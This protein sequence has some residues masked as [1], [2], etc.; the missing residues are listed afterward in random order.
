MILNNTKQIPESIL[1]KQVCSEIRMN[2]LAFKS[3]LKLNADIQRMEARQ[4]IKSLEAAHQR[5][6]YHS[7]A[8]NSDGSIIEISNSSDTTSPQH[9][10][11][12]MRQPIL[13]KLIHFENHAEIAYRLDAIVNEQPIAVFLSQE[14]IGCGTYLCHKLSA[15]GITFFT[16]SPS[17][18]KQYATNLLCLLM[19]Q[20]KQMELIYDEPGWHLTPENNFIFITKEDT[21]WNSLIQITR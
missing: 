21:T 9:L 14:K 2:E 19:G 4:W 17:R 5:S 13:T 20:C 3:Q 18:R 6:L 7:V 16:D 8:L 11:C 10:I 1:E 15:S 12:N